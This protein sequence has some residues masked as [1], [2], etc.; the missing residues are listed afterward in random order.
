MKK[1]LSIALAATVVMASCQKNEQPVQPVQTDDNSISFGLSGMLAEV[2]TRAYSENTATQVQ[3]NG[4]NVAGITGTTTM[5]NEKATFADAK[6]SP[7]NG[8]YYYPASGTMDF[9]AAYPTTQNVTVAG[10]AATLS[11]TQNPDTDL[12]AAK[13]TAVAASDNSVALA[14][15]HI[16]S[17]M[18]FK[19]IG[20]DNKVIYKVKS[21]KIN[22]PTSGTYA[23]ATDTWTAGTSTED[24]VYSSTLTKLSG[25]TAISGAVTVIPCTPTITVEYDVFALDGSETLIHSYTKTKALSSAVSKGKE[26]TVTMTLPNDAAK[27]ITFTI[28]VN[29]WGSE[30]QDI[31]FDED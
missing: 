21:V 25:T 5:F 27:E 14:F 16:L 11:Y 8:P 15:D 28:T 13:A 31:T 18:K 26:C 17:L 3:A 2:Q 4:F 24:N 10:G 6:Y 1:F 9:Y 7:V 19:A 23:Y 22:A 29:Q 20:A 12:L 30:S